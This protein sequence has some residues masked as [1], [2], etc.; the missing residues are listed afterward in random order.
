MNSYVVINEKGQRSELSDL[1]KLSEM[2]VWRK[3]FK[4]EIGNELGRSRQNLMD[5]MERMGWA[6]NEPASDKGHFRFYPTGAMIFGLVSDWLEE[7]A[8]KSKRGSPS[9]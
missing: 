2:S 1:L 6:S 5:L 9:E 3:I 7:I 4:S 8:S